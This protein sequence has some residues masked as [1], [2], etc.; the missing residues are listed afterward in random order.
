MRQP[1]ND[2]NRL[3]EDLNITRNKTETDLRKINR[4]LKEVD[5]SQFFLDEERETPK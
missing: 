1:K 3:R 5:S 2:I 4:V